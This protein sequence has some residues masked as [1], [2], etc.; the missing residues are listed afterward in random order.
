MQR[1]F[2]TMKQALGNSLLILGILSFSIV[3]SLLIFF[4]TPSLAAPVSTEGQKLIQQEKLDRNS[5]KAAEDRSYSYEEQLE[6][7]KDPDKVYEKNVKAYKDS[8][9]G[10]NLVEEA[11]EGAQKLIKNA[12]K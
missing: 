10:E 11:T 1:I 9:P 5:Q 3:S 2:A 8:H 12:T 7:A 4:A 6:A